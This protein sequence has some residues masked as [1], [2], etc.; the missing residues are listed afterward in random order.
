M[1][2][3]REGKR[4]LCPDAFDIMSLT[5]EQ[6]VKAK[7]VIKTQNGGIRAFIH[8]FS[9]IYTLFE[10][11]LEIIQA[12][13]SLD[14]QKSVFPDEQYLKVLARILGKNP[15]LIFIGE[16]AGSILSTLFICRELG[17]QGTILFYKT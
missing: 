1:F 17:C 5:W 14:H 4:D 8:P 2:A 16:E 9:E 6:R 7:D 15:P 3:D 13:K 10:S 12:I 11:P